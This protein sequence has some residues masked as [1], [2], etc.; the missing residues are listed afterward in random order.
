M[1][2]CHV[3]IGL[4]EPPKK[5]RKVAL[6]SLLGGKSKK[7]PDKEKNA[8]LDEHGQYLLDTDV[9]DTD[10]DVL[11]WWRV[12]ELKWPHLGPRQDGQALLCCARLV[13]RR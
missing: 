2:V 4:T 8:P 9:P 6:S 3:E 10:D 1:C 11:K 13:C 12:K 5:M 7:E